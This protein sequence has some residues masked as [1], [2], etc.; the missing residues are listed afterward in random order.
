[1]N[2]IKNITIVGGGLAGWTTALALKKILE[3]LIVE[4]TIIDE[5]KE[6]SELPWLN[7]SNLSFLN[8][9]GIDEK[10]FVKI[11]D[12]TFSLGTQ[13][14]DWGKQ[15]NSFFQPHGPHGNPINF[16]DFH[17]FAIKARALGD[18]KNYEEYAFATSAAKAGKFVH[19]QA[20]QR[21]LLSV[22]NYSHNINPEK[23]LEFF[24]KLATKAGVKVIDSAIEKVIIDNEN[25]S[26]DSICLVNG[27]E[28]KSDFYIDNSGNEALLLNRLKGADSISWE[29]LIPFDSKILFS[30]K[31]DLKSCKP[32]INMNRTEYGYIREYSSQSNQYIEYV[33]DSSKLTEKNAISFVQD[34][35]A[36][37]S[38]ISGLVTIKNGQQSRYWIGNCLSIGNAAV[39]FPPLGVSTIQTVQEAIL[40]FI[41][42]YPNL[43]SL[44]GISKEYNRIFQQR[45]DS[46]RDYVCLHFT[47][48]SN[49]MNLPISIDSAPQTLKEKI[50]LFKVSGK[51]CFQEREFFNH[52]YWTSTLLGLD[53]WPESYDQFLDSFD[54]QELNNNYQRMLAA[55]TQT[56]DQLPNHIEYLK[57]GLE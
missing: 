36:E 10:E 43:D 27:D 14:Y 57:S 53:F 56:T 28:I 3:G 15:G 22:L 55:I 1:M 9:L 18:K 39:D 54:F 52:N 5:Q 21:S 48:L 41:E 37:A 26:I 7:P 42:L 30:R 47:K 6:L 20:D 19:P 33:F 38:P 34:R 44:D 51:I 29:E 49:E 11:S 4:I 45:I 24:R 35:F 25:S 2:A 17:H 23:Y 50:E 13:Y 46:L 31:A 8:Q 32:Q 40:L 12:A 16:L